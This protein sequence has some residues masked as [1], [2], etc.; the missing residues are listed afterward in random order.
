MTHLTKSDWRQLN[1][2]T[3]CSQERVDTGQEGIST[4]LATPG[5]HVCMYVLSF[6]GGE[7]RKCLSALAAG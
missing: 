1:D 7:M 2:I 5:S 4:G 6:Y 3:H